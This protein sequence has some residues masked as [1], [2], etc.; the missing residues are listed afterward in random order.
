M[1]KQTILSSLFALSLS[2]A[3]AANAPAESLRPVFIEGGQYTAVL[4]QGQ[5]SWRLLPADGVDLAVSAVAGCEPGDRL[6][7]G[8]WLVTRDAQGRPMLS[9]PSVTALP[10]GHP[11]QVALRPCG[12]ADGEGLFVAAPQ[13]LIDWLGYNTGAIYVEN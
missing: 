6:P 9:A 3:A 2:T 4:S 5:Q 1:L 12:G 10:A 7:E 11:E 8:I 13:G